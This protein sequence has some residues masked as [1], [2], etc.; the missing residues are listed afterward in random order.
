M[1]KFAVLNI[2]GIQA[3]YL[4]VIGQILFCC[5]TWKPAGISFF[6]QVVCENI[7]TENNGNPGRY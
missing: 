3:Y 5:T 1:A 7:P 6:P 4:L 2:I